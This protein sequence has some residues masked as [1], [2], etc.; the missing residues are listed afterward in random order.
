MVNFIT[1][2]LPVAFI[3][4]TVYLTLRIYKR[5]D[6]RY[7]DLSRIEYLVLYL[8][9]PLISAW[10]LIS[11]LHLMGTK[12]D[13]NNFN[14]SNSRDAFFIAGGLLVV[15]FIYHAVL[16]Y[17]LKIKNVQWKMFPLYFP[18][19]L[20]IYYFFAFDTWG[21]QQNTMITGI[22]TAHV[23]YWLFVDMQ[24]LLGKRWSEKEGII[25]EIRSKTTKTAK[26]AV[27]NSKKAK[28]K[29][30]KDKDGKK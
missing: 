9:F 4:L 28:N 29:I 3:I 6:Q 2:L 30:K 19:S 21:E 23:I 5:F 26:F 16:A 18:V 13:I 14:V 10:S 20:I 1:V 27:E 7:E 12:I 15:I 24:N 17:L 8:V 22:L 11:I 25:S